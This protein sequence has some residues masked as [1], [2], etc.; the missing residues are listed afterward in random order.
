MG[1]RG[2]HDG[3][4]E[5]SERDG[6]TDATRGPSFASGAEKPASSAWSAASLPLLEILRSA[7]D[8]L[9]V[10]DP[11]GKIV[12]ANDAAGRM[13]GWR[14]GTLEGLRI[15]ALLPV[16]QRARHAEFP[17]EFAR[18]P[19]SRPMGAGQRLVGMRADGKTFP[20]DVGLAPVEGAS[21]LVT[22]LVRD[23]T[24]SGR[25]QHLLRVQNVALEAAANAIVITDF[26][27]K[28][29][30][31]NP[32]FTRMTG[33]TAD[34]VV[35]RD[36]SLLKSGAHDGAFYKELWT[37]VSAGRS[38]QGQITNRRKDG[39]LYVEEQTIAPVRG[40]SGEITHFIAIKQDVTERRRVEEA[41]REAKEAAEAAAR[42]KA[43]FLANTSHELR[44]PLNAVLG[45]SE[46]LLE[47]ELD[48][49]QRGML[50]T[51]HQSGESLL[52]LINDLLDF[53]KLEAG[54][55]ELDLHP[56]E[57]EPL[58]ANAVAQVA[59]RAAEKGLELLW[60]IAPAVPSWLVADGLRLSQ[61]LL[62]L[63]GNAVKFTEHGEVAVHLGLGD[64]S[65]KPPRPGTPVRLRVGIRD[66]G[67]GI[68]ADRRHLL[69]KSF[70]Q[71]DASSTRRFGG[72]GLGLA[73]S[74]TL[75]ERMGGAV[76]VESEGVP[77]LGSRF[78]FEIEVTT[79]A[80]HGP[81]VPVEPRLVGRRAAVI[82]PH[83][84]LGQALAM[85]LRA[86]GL[87]VERVP[88]EREDSAP[89]A[90]APPAFARPLEVDVAVVDESA[91][92]A[93]VHRAVGAAPVVLLSQV[94][95]RLDR[96]LASPRVAPVAKPAR[97]RALRDAILRLLERA[98]APDSGPRPSLASRTLPP[99]RL[100]VAEDSAVNQQVI[101]AQLA[102]L[103]VS[104]DLV[105]DGNAALSAIATGRYDLCILDV[106][107]PGLDGL[108]VARAVRKLDGP[109]QRTVLVAL[110]AS[111]MAG[112]RERC[113]A[114]GMDEYVSKPVRLPALEAVL[115]R[116]AATGAD[117]A[118][119]GSIPAAA[120]VADPAPT[121]VADDGVDEPTILE[122]RRDLGDDASFDDLVS[123]F[124]ESAV[125]L[126]EATR[127][128][129]A[130][131]DARAAQRAV[132]T[133]KGSGASC[134]ARRIAEI[135]A[136]L[137]KRFGAGQLDGVEATLVALRADVD[138][139]RV[140]IDALRRRF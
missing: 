24:E 78:T 130:A 85:T 29:H 7:P 81:A 56:V 63:L 47:T 125:E 79:A 90:T 83:A 68:P 132:H 136:Q 138:R 23:L 111:A 106:N 21:G 53:S 135:S 32:A 134:G 20:V 13:F 117:S 8:A 12:F 70:G 65:A 6:G 121:E 67:L 43:E 15:E 129:L 139:Y 109:A 4:T 44:T 34:E 2:E 107:M 19:R 112:D 38:W 42:V 113:L 40:T 126:L 16:D 87:E 55:L 123:T 94:G 77:G 51:V 118:S 92:T 52:A 14:S 33:Y 99:L 69:F 50:E 95:M 46:L 22:C 82:T 74:K 9:I 5:A 26:Q 124:L 86:L 27:G 60:T 73:I 66:T 128:A 30:W 35:G 37:T 10:V 133:L 1:G 103:G 71:L 119:S 72:T 41:Q 105:G 36:P 110:T 48:V 25:A 57:I 75:V 45:F 122:L 93:C 80:P 84:G 140:A 101:S 96:S 131:G 59:P 97:P 115:R 104:A 120:K 98:P 39:S 91:A 89:T 61:I 62:N 114:A 3:A 58:L 100:L 108:E 18:S 11:E 28:I 88:C 64:A 17:G 49:R 31:V 116:A 102:R 137:E 76:E 127:Q 54:R